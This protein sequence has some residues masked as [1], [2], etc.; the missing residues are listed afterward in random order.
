MS[1]KPKKIITPR[2]REQ[3]ALLCAAAASSSPF[4]HETLESVGLSGAAPSLGLQSCPNN[5][6]PAAFNLAFDAKRAANR[7]G[8]AFED[9]HLAC[10]EAECLLRTGFVP[11]GWVG[12]DG[13][14]G[15][16]AS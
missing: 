6:A 1:D 8:L 13:R 11:E 15:E 2:L 12:E 7:S 9:Y 16:A 4:D 14:T 5:D 3:A 10:A